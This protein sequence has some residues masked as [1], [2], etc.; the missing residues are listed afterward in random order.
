MVAHHV[1][2]DTRVFFQALVQDI[3]ESG[4]AGAFR[5]VF[6]TLVRFGSKKASRSRKFRPL[7]KI[8]KPDGSFAA[9]FEEQQKVWLH[10]FA[11]VEAGQLVHWETLVQAN[12]PGLG[13]PPGEH[14]IQVVPTE[15]QILQ[16][17]RK[18]KRGK[19]PGPNMLPPDVF[20]VGDQVVAKQMACLLA[21]TALH[22][23]EPISWKGG[24][25]VPLFKKGDTSEPSSYRS[26]FVSD[27]SAKIYHATIRKQ[28]LDIWQKSI[29]HL[30]YGGRPGKATDNAH[31]HLQSHFFWGKMTKCSVAALYFDLKSAFYMVLREVLVEGVPNGASTA[32]ALRRL[33][34]DHDTV[35]SLLQQA[36][37]E[38]ATDGLSPHAARLVLDVLSGTYFQV[39][40]IE[41]PV[42]THRGTRPGDPVGDVLFNLT[43]SKIVADVKQQ[44]THQ[45]GICWTGKDTQG[46][47]FANPKP[48]AAPFFTDVSYVDDCVYCLAA[49]NNDQLEE[50]AAVVVDAMILAASKR[51]LQVNFARGK[52]EIMCHPAGKGIRAW[53]QKVIQN[54]D[55][56]SWQTNGEDRYVRVVH[57][58]RHLG[59]WVQD[60]CK[61]G[62]EIQQRISSAR[63]SWGPLARN[64][65]AKKGVALK[66]K[67]Q[68]F[69]SLTMS[70]LTYNAHVWEGVRANELDT[71]SNSLR[72]ALYPLVKGKLHGL[73]PYSCGVETLCGLLK[74]TAPL[75]GLHVARLR[76]LK[77][78][79]HACPQCLWDVLWA[80]RCFEDS[81]ILSCQ[82][83]IAWLHKFSP[84]PLPLGPDDEFVVWLH[85]ISVDTQWKGR[86]KAAAMSCLEYRLATAEQEVWQR[87]VDA[88]L[89]D[90]GLNVAFEERQKPEEK[91]ECALCSMSFPSKRGL[92]MHAHKIHGYTKKVK[93]YALHETCP[94]CLK[95]YHCR[96]RLCSH[97]TTSHACM[98]RLTAC[99]PPLSDEKVRELDESDRL[100]RQV[101]RREGWWATKAFQ[102]VLQICGPHLPPVNSPEAL[103]LYLKTVGRSEEGG[104]AFHGLQG[105]QVNE[106]V[107][108]KPPDQEPVQIRAFV[109][110]S[111]GGEFVGDGLLDHANLARGYAILHVK[112]RLFVHFFSGFRREG[113]LHSIIMQQTQADSSQMFIISVDLCLQKSLGDLSTAS[114][115]SFWLDKI[116]RGFVIGAGGGPPCETFTA[117]R[118]MDGGPPPLRDADHLCGLPALSQKQWVQVHIGMR[119]VRFI[120]EILLCLS[121]HGGCGFC[122]HPQMPTW[123]MHLS[124]P[125]IWQMKAVRQLKRL[126]CISFISFDQCIFDVDYV[127]PTTLMLLRLPG[128][129]TAVRKLGD[130][131]RC[132]HGRGKHQALKGK[133]CDGSFATSVGKI[134]PAPMNALLGKAICEFA[135]TIPCGE[136]TLQELPLELSQFCHDV[137]ADRSHVQPDFYAPS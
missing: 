43:M 109:L 32:Q 24:Y 87:N 99:Y 52:T 103:I 124:P 27:Y 8:R 133:Q 74:L 22:A 107:H 45:T 80:N 106:V 54:G 7:P 42:R 118:F 96:A 61:H 53:K 49:E 97:L 75:D 95:F 67:V 105:R 20:K 35:Q 14:E 116:A 64:F 5:A 26:I 104:Q 55:K 9:D 85:C 30:H 34:M 17:I 70:R 69:S 58:Y 36:A 88:K 23:R 110:D 126:S 2:R 128:F 98:E 33:G 83:S 37:H 71:W 62:K 46:C 115:L 108:D 93:Y 77:R 86:V 25:V 127:K 100:A 3:H 50:L 113:D 65:Y 84:K 117:A 91:W 21:K 94:A 73:P 4:E 114:S 11:D 51:G 112:C 13:I 63:S 18:M 135:G 101:L 16:C 38:N 137:F 121:R 12:R 39:R 57:V 10:Q 79:V 125:S 134:Y 122:E 76:Y 29:C 41:T 66:S 92:A 31:H 111:P 60:G 15:D 119:L 78:F 48:V 28:L 89:H 47:D 131:G 68:I 72:P 1:Y 40:G 130:Q 59:S 82:A 90:L 44:V 123:I 129:R 102:P 19:T 136:D 56:I 120:L 6:R 132:S 81:W